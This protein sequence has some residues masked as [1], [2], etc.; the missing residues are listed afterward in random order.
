MD[1]TRADSA[2]TL[3]DMRAMCA[4][5]SNWGRWGQDDELGTLNFIT[6]ERLVRAAGLVKRGRAFS[7]AIPL[8]EKGPQS[9]GT[10]RFNPIHT[11]LKD[12]ADITAGTFARDFAGG[13][14]RELKAIDDLLFMPL[15]A[16]TQ[17]D[18][19]SHIVHQ[20]KIWNGVDVSWVTSKGARRN[21]IAKARESLIGRGV[22]LDFP[23]FLSKDWLDQSTPIDGRLLSECAKAQG[24]AIASGDIVLVRT[25][26]MA[27]VRAEGAWNGYDNINAGQPG[28][29]I[30]AG[31]WLHENEI[32]AVATDTLAVEATPST[33]PE[34]MLPLHILCLVYMGVH[35]GEIFD[36]DDLAADCAE[37]RVYEFLF[38]GP[39]L[40]VTG[41]VGAPVN[42]IALK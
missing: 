14:D 9:G 28:L 15:Q 5:Y 13:A 18:A 35:L 19:L 20:G 34:A 42:P 30:D 1:A 26:R 41:A 38:V 16:S 11:M 4:K 3:D 27:R 25:G 40:P 7:L 33:I 10:T 22:L 24:V 8:D 17:W 37:D 12:G 6:P 36:L 29:G 39:P 31:P 2:L 21:D 32:A 23:R